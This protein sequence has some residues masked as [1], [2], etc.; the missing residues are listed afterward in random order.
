VRREK[1]VFNAKGCLVGRACLVCLTL[2]PC[3]FSENESGAGA[4]GLVD[5][6]VEDGL[7]FLRRAA[8]I[9]LFSGDA[10]KRQPRLGVE[11][12]QCRSQHQRVA[13]QVRVSALGQYR[14]AA[15]GQSSAFA[16]LPR[17]FHQ[18]FHVSRL[19]LIFFHEFKLF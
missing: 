2:N 4:C 13:R 5:G 18:R 3:D 16:A 11:R 7:G 1:L 10:C 14:G 6:L 17:A 9:A 12:F 15:S 8:K 19:G